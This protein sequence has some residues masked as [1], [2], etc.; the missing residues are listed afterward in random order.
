MPLAA[1]ALVVA[2]L[3]LAAGLSRGIGAMAVLMHPSVLSLLIGSALMAA[4]TLHDSDSGRAGQV[5]LIAAAGGG[6]IMDAPNAGLTGPFMYVYGVL[7]AL[8][9]G[10]LVRHVRL[11]ATLAVLVL[12]ALLV[13]AHWVLAGRSPL[14][15][16][17]TLL[18][19]VL[20]IY[21]FWVLFRP[22]IEE[23]ENLSRRLNQIANRRAT[24]LEKANAELSGALEH[25]RAL[26]RELQHRVRNNLASVDGL[27][28][29]QVE[30]EPTPEARAALQAVSGRVH[31]I[32]LVHDHTFA[33]DHGGVVRFAELCERLSADV[34]ERAG[35]AAPNRWT[36]AMD[37]DDVTLSADRAFPAALFVAECLTSVAR[38]DTEAQERTATVRL[39]ATEEQVQLTVTASIPTPPAREPEME[40]IAQ[41][42]S[43]ELRGR[44]QTIDEPGCGW[45]LTFQQRE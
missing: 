28:E 43:G 33:H 26:T 27:V 25:N 32:A 39:Q 45:T 11:K 12:A 37:V 2:V 22:E 35:P 34:L 8:Q 38:T 14:G 3:N 36:V 9:Y 6:A 29:L 20:S 42:V 7:L 13:L 4:A 44:I 10:F 24:E 19:S 16:V 18:V 23:R 1:V 41:L 15:V 31:A 5:L 21:L 30:R 17:S 40:L